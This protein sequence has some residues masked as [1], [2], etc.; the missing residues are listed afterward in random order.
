MGKGLHPPPPGSATALDPILMQTRC[1][2]CERCLNV[3]LC[4]I[5][6][7]LKLYWGLAEAFKRSNME[8]GVE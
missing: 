1:L 3:S 2:T 5:F 7:M 4:K 6:G 8:C